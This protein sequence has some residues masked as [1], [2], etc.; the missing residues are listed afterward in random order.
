[1]KGKILL[2][3]F[4]FVKISLFSQVKGKVVDVNNNPIAYVNIWVQNETIGTTSDEDGSFYLPVKEDK[5]LIFSA[6]GFEKVF[7]KSSEAALVKMK[8]MTY[9]L[10]EVVVLNKKETKEVEIGM[11]TSFSQAFE[12][13]PKTDARFFPYNA[14]VKKNRYIKKVSIFTENNLETATVKIHFYA[15]NSEG[16][17]GEEL[18]SK[19]LIVQVKKGSRKTYFDVS[20]RNIVFPR[21]GLFVSVERL[22]IDKN[23]FSKTSTAADGT[24]KTHMV[25]YP[26]LFYN[27]IE[28]DFTYTFY[29]GNWH[30]EFKK[31]ADT[32]IK[33]RVFEPS[34]TLI[35]TN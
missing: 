24:T 26:L 9:E 1:M 27:Y 11:P 12:N 20:N 6:I 15:V 8:S 4:L 28:R 21:E 16:L 22:F 3:L 2:I 10:N 34:I 17:P 13:G 29:G 25:Y 23:K 31:S 19:D 7:I 14:K 5:V 33:N 18:L 35:L 32:T 30:K